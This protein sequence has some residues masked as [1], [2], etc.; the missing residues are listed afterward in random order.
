MCYCNPGFISIEG[1]CIPDDGSH[2][3]SDWSDWG[4]CSASCGGNGTQFREMTDRDMVIIES[5]S[6]NRELCPIDLEELVKCKC[7]T[8]AWICHDNSCD[9]GETC[10]K[11][12]FQN[13]D[14]RCLPALVG[15]CKAWGD[16]HIGRIPISYYEIH[17]SGNF[18]TKELKQI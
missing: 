18:I 12:N 5:R 13:D 11:S 10:Q 8:D 15:E 17:S 4:A 6:C 1:E 2:C 3:R 7:P 16:P 9:L 14:F